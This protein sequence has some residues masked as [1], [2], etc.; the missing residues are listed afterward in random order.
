MD[1]FMRQSIKFETIFVF[2]LRIFIEY[3]DH[4][5]WR[6]SIVKIRYK[7]TSSKNIAEE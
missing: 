3:R 1:F 2:K 6:I 5:S 4:R 7:E